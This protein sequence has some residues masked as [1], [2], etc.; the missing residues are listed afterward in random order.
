MITSQALA[1]SGKP[2]AST[3]SFEWLCTRRFALVLGFI[4]AAAFPQ[5]LLGTQS[6]VFRDFGLFGYPIAHYHRECFWRGELPFWNPLNNCGI[7]FLAQ[8]NTLTLYPLS[9]IYLLL[10]MPWSLNLFCLIHL[11]LA[12]IGMFCLTSR[13]T[14]CRAGAAVAGMAFAL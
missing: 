14:N 8:W 11:Y 2:A 13:W 10:P 5:I 7:P 6:F 1:S 9:L 4:I 12:G 3:M